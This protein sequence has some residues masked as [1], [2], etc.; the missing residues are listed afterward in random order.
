M[1]NVNIKINGKDY[2]VADDL[3]ILEAAKSVGITIPTLCWLKDIT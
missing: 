1:G 3:T 2:S